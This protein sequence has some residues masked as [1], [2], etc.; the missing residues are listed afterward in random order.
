MVKTFNYFLLK[1]DQLLSI[2]TSSIT[3]SGVT[4]PAVSKQNVVGCV[5]VAVVESVVDLHVTDMNKVTPVTS[6]VVEE[7]VLER[8]T[9]NKLNKLNFE[10]EVD[11]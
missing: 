9:I 1:V 11:L 6:G 7:I 4:L 10:P 3:T 8:N 2:I 5:I